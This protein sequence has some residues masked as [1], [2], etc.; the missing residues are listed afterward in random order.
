MT[1]ALKNYYT[2]YGER[3]QTTYAE[4]I[5][6]TFWAG[7]FVQL[8]ASGQVASLIANNSQ[9]TTG[10]G[11]KVAGIALSNAQNRSVVDTNYPT[12]VLPFDQISDES[13]IT[14]PLYNAGTPANACYN[15]ALPG[16][17]FAISNVNGIYV[18]DTS[19]T[20][21]TGVCQIVKQFRDYGLSDLQTPVQVKILRS[22][23]FFQ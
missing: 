16:L 10:T 18:C 12:G 2:N 9:W 20:G 8:N 19:V 5:S 14:L 23:L 11:V 7:A 4:A 17:I 3:P 21:A 1:Y 6:Q 15:T 13:L 22:Q